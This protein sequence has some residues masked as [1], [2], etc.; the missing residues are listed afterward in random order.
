MTASSRYDD[1]LDWRF[2]N[3]A[4]LAFSTVHPM[5]DLKKPFFAVGINIVADRGTARSNGFAQHDL[6]AGV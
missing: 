3:Q 1:A 2:A 6:N 4:R 5:L